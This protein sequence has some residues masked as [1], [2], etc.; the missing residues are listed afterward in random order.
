[1]PI[2][3]SDQNVKSGVPLGGIGAGKLEIMPNGVLDNFT[4]L[5]SLHKPLSSQGGILGFNFVLSTKDK[6]KRTTKLLGVQTVGDCPGVEAIK[7]DGSFPFARLEY[8]DRDLPVEVTLEAFS[9]FIPKD[10]KNSGLP[11]VF[12]KFKISN[13]HARTVDVSLMATARNIIGDWCV[14]RFN[15]VVDAEKTLNLFFY[16]KKTQAQDP[17]SGEMCL[18]VLKNKK[19]GASYLGEWN[20]QARHFVFDKT[21]V[22]LGEAAAA[23][24]QEGCLPNVNSEKVVVSE[25]YQLGGALCAQAELKPKTSMTVTFVLSWFFPGYAEGRMYETWFRNVSDV[26]QYA[27]AHCDE[28]LAKTKEWTK[29]LAA[30]DIDNWLKDALVN[31]L[32]PLVSG[33]LWTKRQ[34]FGL[35][36]A[37]EVCPLLGTMDV[38]FYGSLPLALFFPQLELKEMQ[39][40]AEAQ[41]PQGYIPHDLGFKRSDLASNSTNGLLWKDLN[42]KFILLV[43]RDFLMTKDENFLKKMYP[44]VKKA[45]YWLAAT[46]KNKD[47]LPDNEGPDQ[48]FDLWG[49]YGANAYTSGIFLAGL[50][51]LERIA[52]SLQDEDMRKEAE[53]WF[54]KGRTSFEKKL[55]HKKYFIA[56][57]NAKEG[58]SE[59]QL[60]HHVKSQKV[61]ISCMAAQLTG[62]WIAHLLGLGYIASEEKIKKA[63]ATILEW[64]ATASPFG[65]VNAVLPTG[66]KDKSNWHSENVWFGVT[67]ALGSLA[68]FEGFQKEGLSLAKKAWDNAAVNTL[69]P[70]NQPDMYSSSDGSPIFGDHDM[71]NMVI[72]AI[73]FALAKKNKSVAN[74]LEMFKK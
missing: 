70:W 72:W 8:E 33:S 31:N 65:A 48:T 40:F 51:A 35:F 59:H 13:P 47:Y 60:A 54:K 69:N 24:V 36:E 46:D 14:G 73:L 19:L 7:F 41:R 25:S 9:P 37:P 12:F 45:F 52:V 11:L 20:M 22:T 62:Q 67:Y 15:Q 18:S 2:Y 17:S 1:M 28:L 58:L 49:F 32:Y 6:K 71:R 27:A 64:N 5:N 50:L 10:E 74:F 66:E 55:W 61:N 26:A 53:L 42:A 34:R 56:Y 16:N 68:I 38:R 3:T 43:Y 21:S 29:A 4:F 57:N 23:L 63:L 30:L 39:E 44:F